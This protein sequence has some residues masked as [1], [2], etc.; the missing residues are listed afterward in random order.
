MDRFTTKVYY[1]V[2]NAK[3]TFFNGSV[4]SCKNHQ[5]QLENETELARFLGNFYNYLD[6]SRILTQK[7]TVSPAFSEIF[8]IFHNSCFTKN[9][10]DG[11]FVLCMENH[12][13]Q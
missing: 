5:L 9:S 1:V 4:I 13:H 8:G 6:S 10:Q 3:S 11:C 12:S 2:P 7:K